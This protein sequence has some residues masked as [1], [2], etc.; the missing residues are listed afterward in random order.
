MRA[1]VSSDSAPVS[2]AERA[3]WDRGRAVVGIDEVGRGAWAGPVTVAAV[4]LAPDALPSG[5]RDSKQLTP[6]ARTAA[7]LRVRSDGLVA[8]GRA[9]NDEIDE[10]GLAGALGLAVRRAF[11][12]LC[13][14]PAA[15]NDPLVLIDGPHDLLR[16]RDVEVATLVSGDAFSIS[17]AAASVVAKVDR[18]AEMVRAAA[19][20]PAY[21]FERNKG[22]PSPAHVAALERDGACLLHRHSWAPLQRLVQ[23]R[24]ALD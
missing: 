19:H 14:L 23:P 24:L 22:Y 5:V 21:A 4:V 13:A 6:Q 16:E 1:T 3:A 7:D 11:K 2:P 9:S 8:L 18:D 17:I 15:P 12:D 20:H 10:F